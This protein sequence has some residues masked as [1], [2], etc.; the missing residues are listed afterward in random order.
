LARFESECPFI[1]P[2]SACNT[3]TRVGKKAVRDKTNGDHK[4]CWESI[5]GFKYAKGFP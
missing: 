4:K 5:K 3:R 1:G 2:E